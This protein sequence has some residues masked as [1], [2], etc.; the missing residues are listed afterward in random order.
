MDKHLPRMAV[1]GAATLEVALPDLSFLVVPP[2]RAKE[3][4]T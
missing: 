4:R 3:E 1:S 2:M